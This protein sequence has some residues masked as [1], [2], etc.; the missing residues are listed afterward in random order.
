[1]RCGRAPLLELPL[2]MCKL[3]AQ[4]PGARGGLF[5]R[6]ASFAAVWSRA[7]LRVGPMVSQSTVSSPGTCAMCP[8]RGGGPT[9]VRGWP[10]LLLGRDRSAGAVPRKHRRWRL[11]TCER[12]G[13]RGVQGAWRGPM[14]LPGPAAGPSPLLYCAGP[15]DRLR[16]EV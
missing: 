4:L 6:D 11:Q 12:A 2:E 9:A 1:M 15:V 8:G 3:T 7:K 16:A 13:V 10:A 14:R 5:S